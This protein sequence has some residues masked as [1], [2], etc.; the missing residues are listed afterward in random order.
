MTRDELFEE[1]RTLL[2]EPQ[3]DSV[4]D[5]WTYSDE[6]L[7]LQVRSTLR[8]LKAQGV[9]TTADMGTDGTMSADLTARHGALVSLHV[10]TKLLRGDMI[11]KLNSGELG[12]YFKSGTDVVDTKTVANNFR[13]VSTKYDGE[14]EVLLL[15]SLN[16]I[17]GAE[18]F[19]GPTLS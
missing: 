18:V 1:I 15:L 19:G 12:I 13:D 2:R 5:P 8:H 11:R 17:N 9:T 6:D 4:S 10:A 16:D 14:Y 3:L 7:I